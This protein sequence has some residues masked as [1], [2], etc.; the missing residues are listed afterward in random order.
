MASLNEA[1]RVPQRYTEREILNNSYDRTSNSIRANGT[2]QTAVFDNVAFSTTTVDAYVATDSIVVP[3][4]VTAFPSGAKLTVTV[5]G[6]DMFGNVST[7]AL[8][9]ASPTAVG[10]TNLT[11]N[12]YGYRHVQISVAAYLVSGSLSVSG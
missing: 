4:H 9:T 6:I 8:G 1:F 5:Y 7:V 10:D 2:I 3:I 12:T 11:A